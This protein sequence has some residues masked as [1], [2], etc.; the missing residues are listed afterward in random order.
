MEIRIKTIEEIKDIINR[1]ND[2]NAQIMVIPD[3]IDFPFPELYKEIVTKYS[4]LDISP[5][6]GLF[7]L[8]KSIDITN[9]IYN[10]NW[11]MEEKEKIKNYWFIGDGYSYDY[12]IIDKMGNMNYWKTEYKKQYELE[13]I[14]NIK[15]DF[16]QWLKFAYIDKETG[17]ELEKVSDSGY[18]EVIYEPL[19]NEIK[20]NYLE[21]VK[22]FSNELYDIIIKLKHYKY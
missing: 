22:I 20:D 13:K 8:L 14:I 21:M 5:F 3:K 11:N 17:K 12:W 6:C 18:D 19:C 10:K 2:G 9:N 15:M 1:E 4:K 7:S 16:E